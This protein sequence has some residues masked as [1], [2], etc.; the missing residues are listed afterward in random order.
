M[1]SHQSEWASL[2]LQVINDGEGVEKKEP[3]YIVGGNVINRHYGDQY[4]GSLKTSYHKTLQSH[5]WACMW[6]KQ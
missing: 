4:G 3:S 5:S 1:K 2:S 6:R